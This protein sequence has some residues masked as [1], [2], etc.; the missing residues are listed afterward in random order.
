MVSYPQIS[1]NPD[2]QTAGKLAAYQ[3]VASS[4]P[5]YWNGKVLFG[6]QRGDRLYVATSGKQI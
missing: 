2:C 4:I 6:Y 1:C 3:A 5:A